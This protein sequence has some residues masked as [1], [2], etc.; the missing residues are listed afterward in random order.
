MTYKINWVSF[1]DNVKL[2]SMK[3][4][5]FI[6][7]T[8]GLSDFQFQFIHSCIAKFF[9]CR[10]FSNQ[11]FQWFLMAR[12]NAVV[13]NAMVNRIQELI[14]V[15][16][17]FS[18]QCM[19]TQPSISFLHDFYKINKLNQFLQYKIRWDLTSLKRELSPPINANRYV[20]HNTSPEKKCE[21]AKK[22]T[23]QTT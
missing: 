18:C 21:S 13:I 2:S 14:M 1:I 19:N 15:I 6:Y 10:G 11:I 16:S 9:E 5:K 17:V 23:S 20:I 7:Q 8:T 4:V 22:D 12:T 3:W